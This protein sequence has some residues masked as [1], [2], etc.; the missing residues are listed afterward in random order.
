MR[1]VR[2]SELPDVPRG[3]SLTDCQQWLLRDGPEAQAAVYTWEVGQRRAVTMLFIGA[4]SGLLGFLVAGILG[5]HKYNSQGF[6]QLFNH[7]HTVLVDDN[8]MGEPFSS[9]HNY[10]PQTVSELVHNRESPE[11]KAFFAFGLISAVCIL[12]SWYPTQLRNV[13]IGDD[14][15]LCGCGGP[16]WQNLRQFMPPVGM[17]LV[18]CIPTVP[19]VNRTVGDKIT[20]CL[21]TLGAVM[22]VGGYSLCE[23]VALRSAQNKTGRGAILKPYEWSVRAVLICLSLLSGFAFQICGALSPKPVD[24]L[25]TDSC[26]DVW[27]VPSKGDLD[28]VMRGLG[29]DS[30]DLSLAVQISQAMHDHQLLLLDTAH[31]WCL[32]L[33]FMEYWFEVLAGIFMVASHLAVWWFCPER[34]LNLPETLP[35]LERKELQRQGYSQRMLDRS[36]RDPEEEVS[37]SDDDDSDF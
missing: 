19:P 4:V 27:V 28:F 24:S 22:M 14:V 2:R 1:N 32:Q 18:A 3:P 12:I 17:L 33:K 25:G 23:I 30:I 31:G 34:K 6:R 7:N 8:F 16:T 20:V 15:V 36:A 26:A 10:R 11:G 5:M 21:H 29:R 9:G 13:Y 37:S 35:S